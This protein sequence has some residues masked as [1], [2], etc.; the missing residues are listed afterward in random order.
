MNILTLI[1]KVCQ[2][3]GLQSPATVLGSTDTRVLQLLGLA[4]EE[5]NDLAS[6]H[7]WQGLTREAVH[8]TIANEDQGDIETLDPGFRYIRNNTVWDTTD[9]LPVIGPIDGQQW[10]ALKAVANTGP[11]YQFRFRG[12]HLLVTPTPAAGHTWK[13]EYVQRYPILDVDGTTRKE[14]FTKD[15]DTF[16]IP[17][18]LVL[19]GV[20]WRFMREKGLSY[21]ELFQAYEMQVKDAM[22]RD[23]GHRRLFGDDMD[24]VLRP[25]IFVPSGSWPLP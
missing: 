8:V 4:E 9:K 18:S 20:R 24:R 25:G 10:Q 7:D 12:N 13:F 3:T 1:Q 21:G 5:I 17:D 11:R 23:G 15:T 14:F 16:L 22:S 19:L 6:R 2:R